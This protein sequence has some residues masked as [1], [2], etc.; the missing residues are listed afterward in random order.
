MASNPLRRVVDKYEE[1]K[2][3]FYNNDPNR[4]K[5]Q[6]RKGLWAFA[7]SFIQKKQ[8]KALKI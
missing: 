8:Q 5:P 3:S 7:N 1:L 4:E 6:E 2:K